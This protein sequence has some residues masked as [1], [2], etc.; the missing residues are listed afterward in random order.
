M[1]ETILCANCRQ[2]LFE[3]VFNTRWLVYLCDDVRCR[4]YRQ[5]QGSRPRDHW[6][7]LAR[8]VEA[9]PVKL[10]ILPHKKAS[11]YPGYGKSQQQQ[12]EN[13]RAARRLG[14]TPEQAQAAR[15]NKGL[16]RFADS[17]GALK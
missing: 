6:D 4:L 1:T 5:P 12:S 13:Y 10:R 7:N 14:A 3:L 8:V 9:E 11:E 17:A 16:R 2:P 15:T